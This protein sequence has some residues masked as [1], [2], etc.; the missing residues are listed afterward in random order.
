TSPRPGIF[1]HLLRAAAMGMAALSLT[2]GIALSRRLIAA[3]T[4]AAL[5]VPTGYLF[6]RSRYRLPV[7]L[8]ALALFFGLSWALA[9]F[10]VTSPPIPGLIGPAAALAASAAIRFGTTAFVASAALRTI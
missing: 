9:S 2:W 3:V 5:G 1:R 4:G 7:A 6:G 8:A 10:T